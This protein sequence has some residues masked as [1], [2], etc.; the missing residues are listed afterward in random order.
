M[1]DLPG[2]LQAC[3]SMG[4]VAFLAILVSG[5]IVLQILLDQCDEILDRS[6]DDRKHCHPHH[7]E[8]CGD[9]RLGGNGNGPL[10]VRSIR[11]CHFVFHGD[12]RRRR[13]HHVLRYCISMAM[14]LKL[15]YL[16]LVRLLV[17]FI[18]V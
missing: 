12:E 7:S 15:C 10:V 6:L 8:A 5:G 11:D 13:L 4:K 17:L 18:L 1:A 9:H 2:S 16:H 3:L 14:K